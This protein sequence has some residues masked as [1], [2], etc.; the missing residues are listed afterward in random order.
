M[1]K[2]IGRGSGIE[3]GRARE[4]R[5][6]E[7]EKERKRGGEINKIPALRTRPIGYP[8]RLV[9]FSWERKLFLTL[10]CLLSTLVSTES[11]LTWPSSSATNRTILSCQQPAS[12]KSSAVMRDLQGKWRWKRFL[13][14]LHSIYQQAYFF[15][16]DVPTS[17]EA[18]GEITNRWFPNHSKPAALIE[19]LCPVSH[20]NR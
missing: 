2:E 14:D 17:K 10:H 11:V 7:E 1:Y 15:L 13:L 3:R 8:T 12:R 16:D 18:T 5:E 4:K 6:R 19:K 20:V 9:H